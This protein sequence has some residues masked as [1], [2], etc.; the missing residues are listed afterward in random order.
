MTDNAR[1]ELCG[2]VLSSDGCIQGYCDR[3]DPLLEER[4]KMRRLLATM[5]LPPNN[6]PWLEVLR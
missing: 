3:H 1:I 4:A 6:V 5:R 2:C